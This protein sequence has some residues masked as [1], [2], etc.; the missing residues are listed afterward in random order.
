MAGYW[1]WRYLQNYFTW[2]DYAMEEKY[3]KCLRRSVL[4]KNLSLFYSQ[5]FEMFTK[6][7]FMIIMVD[8]QDNRQDLWPDCAILHQA[9]QHITCGSGHNSRL[10]FV[11]FWY[12]EGSKDTKWSGT[13]GMC[14]FLYHVK[15]SCYCW[16]GDNCRGTK[17]LFIT[18]V[19]QKILVQI[20]DLIFSVLFICCNKIN[21]AFLRRWLL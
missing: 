11:A 17:S 19:I 7:C 9:Q 4:V 16:W 3:H 6:H 14:F 5:I 1:S 8:K 13:K 20:C 10:T 15:Y 18:N 12:H 2:H 21:Q